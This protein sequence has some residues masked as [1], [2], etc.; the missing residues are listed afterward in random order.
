MAAQNGRRE[1]FRLEAFS[2]R[3]ARLG[4]A[5]EWILEQARHEGA[6]IGDAVTTD[7]T[8]AATAIAQTPDSADDQFLFRKGD[9]LKIESEIVE[10]QSV[11][12]S[13]T[14]ERADNA[15]GHPTL[16]IIKKAATVLPP[17]AQHVL[18]GT[19]TAA[20]NDSVTTFVVRLNPQLEEPIPLGVVQVLSNRDV[21]REDV[22]VT[23]YGDITLN[24]ARGSRSTTAAAHTQPFDLKSVNG[25]YSVEKMWT[26]DKLYVLVSDA[27]V[28]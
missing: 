20:V 12:I 11:D 14:V 22:I 15:R 10:V 2:K 3:D 27:G 26:D 13:L 18:Y 4:N 6:V 9:L 21:I 24:V 1:K 8:D 16:R 25:P 28:V 19:L 23:A 7:L 5:E 17:G